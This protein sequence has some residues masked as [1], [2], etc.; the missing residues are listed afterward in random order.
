MLMTP[1]LCPS[2]GKKDVWT[3]DLFGQYGPNGFCM[4]EA[5]CGSCNWNTQA[6]MR[7][8]NWSPKGTL[9]VEEEEKWRCHTCGKEETCCDGDLSRRG[10]LEDH[11]CM[12]YEARDGCIVPKEEQPV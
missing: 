6:E 7:P 8:V 5:R 9:K 1:T 2:C 12:L 3:K 4:K 11:G 10:M